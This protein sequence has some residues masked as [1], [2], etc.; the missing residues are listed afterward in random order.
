M[1]SFSHPNELG[2]F[3]ILCYKVSVVLAAR[4]AQ[5]FQASRSRAIPL[6]TFPGLLTLPV[7]TTAFQGY[8]SGVG[9][10]Q[11]IIVDLEMKRGPIGFD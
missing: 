1:T 7:S 11:Q 10:V 8:V 2:I 6:L 4:K 3:E 5:N 9:I